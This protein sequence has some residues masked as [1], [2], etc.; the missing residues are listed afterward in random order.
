MSAQ[1]PKHVALVPAAGSGQRFGAGIPKQY[2]LLVGAP[3]LVHTV[4]TLLAY[5]PF[6][7]VLVIVSAQDDLAATVLAGVLLEHP[8]RLQLAY[9]GG[10]TRAATVNN[11]LR[12]LLDSGFADDTWVWVHDAARPGIAATQLNDLQLAMSANSVGV[13]LAT[14]V[15]D[16]LKQA[17]STD[18]TVPVI[19]STVPRDALWQAQTPQCFPLQ[20]LCDAL[21]SAAAQGLTVTDEASAIEALGLK[22]VLV[23]GSS[24]NFKVTT[25]ADAAL[26]EAVLTMRP[27]KDMQKDTPP[28]SPTLLNFPN[29][30]IGEGM[31]VHALVV[32]RPLI[33][34]GVTISHSKGLLGHSDADALL[35]AITDALLGAAG[36][37]DI[38]RMFPDTDAAHKGADSQILLQQAY[39]AVAAAG[40]QVV[41]V[42]ATI[43]VQAPKMAAHIPTMQANI[44]RCLNVDN[45]C[46]NVKAKT[47]EKLGWLGREE[48]IE[49]RAVIMLAKR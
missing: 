11:G 22:P 12:A 1:Q 38:G 42:D 13:I 33:L 3:M 31:D 30:R 36:M 49:T 27:M 14:P 23:Q 29:I 43:V 32:G 10:D 35:H 4:R 6:G 5:G 46:V 48:G 24:H 15:A 7:V 40:W 26:M 41:N 45:S 16:T 2:S 18:G 25:P 9:I 17:T 20:L 19:Q 44:A 34:G 28:P 21:D 8:Q 37:G 47:N 39:A